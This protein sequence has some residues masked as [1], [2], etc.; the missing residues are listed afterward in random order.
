MESCW[1]C[2]QNG[3]KFCDGNYVEVAAEDIQIDDLIGPSWLRLMGRKGSTTIDEP[4][5]TGESLPV[6]NQLVMQLSLHYQQQWDHSL[7]AE[8]R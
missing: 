5:V 3:L 2:R 1:I 8:S 7:K 4:M 6:E